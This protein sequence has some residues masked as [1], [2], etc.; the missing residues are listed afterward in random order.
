MA[1]ADTG[2]GGESG[3]P[4]GHFA[5]TALQAAILTLV[6]H[7]FLRRGDFRRHFVGLLNSLRATPIDAEFRGGKYRLHYQDNLAECGLLFSPN[8]NADDIDFL[9]AGTPLGGVFLDVGANVGLYT[10]PLALKA[11][12][13]GRAVAV[14]PGSEAL[15]RLRFNVAASA[16]ANVVVLPYAAGDGDFRADLHLPAE[17]LAL[18]RVVPAAEGSVRVRPLVDMLAEA[19]ITRVD[20]MKV[21]VEGF[22]DRVVPPFFERAPRSLWPQRICLEPSTLYGRLAIHDFLGG[23]GFVEVGRNKKNSLFQTKDTLP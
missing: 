13:A 19:G 11:G 12:P 3:L 4:F 16:L 5:P 22:Q 10:I 15:R 8:Y 18:F 2:N 6:R 23:L 9:L 20:T 17:D 21:D 1:I 7:S 14:E